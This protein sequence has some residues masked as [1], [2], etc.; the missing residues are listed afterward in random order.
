MN[1]G[2]VCSGKE[3]GMKFFKEIASF[4]KVYGDQFENQMYIGKG[5]LRHSY[6]L[7]PVCEGDGL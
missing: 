6:P 1:R 5:Q 3:F 2:T 7:T 4:L